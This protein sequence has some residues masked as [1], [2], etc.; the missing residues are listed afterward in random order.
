MRHRR[1]DNTYVAFISVFVW[2]DL[3]KFFS[4]IESDDSLEASDDVVTS[5]A[6]RS[7]PH[8]S[9]HGRSRDDIATLL[10][11]LQQHVGAERMAWQKHLEADSM[12]ARTSLRLSRFDPRPPSGRER[13]KCLFDLPFSDLISAAAVRNHI[14]HVENRLHL[15]SR[16]VAPKT[17]KRECNQRRRYGS[18]TRA[19]MKGLDLRST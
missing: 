6:P 13:Y 3:M 18:N 10:A 8:S 19:W 5:H 12:R 14:K 16:G 7:R 17:L 1:L 9:H 4:A 2:G 11:Q 15:T